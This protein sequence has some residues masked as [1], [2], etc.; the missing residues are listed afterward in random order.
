MQ[1]IQ[2]L[3][4]ILDLLK[5]DDKQKKSIINDL[6]LNEVETF[7]VKNNKEYL[8]KLKTGFHMQKSKMYSDF[9]DLAKK[10]AN[11][12]IKVKQLEAFLDVV[13]QNVESP[14]GENPNTLKKKKID[15]KC[16]I[17]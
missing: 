8:E 2:R 13:K 4:E 1:E 10:R 12:E 15:E 9:G 7:Q 3:N 17:Y 11:D 5:I 6:L 16:I 14:N